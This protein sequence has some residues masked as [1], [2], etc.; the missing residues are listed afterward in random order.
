MQQGQS[1]INNSKEGS[2]TRLQRKRSRLFIGG[3][4]Q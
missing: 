4:E 3:E 1:N 2:G